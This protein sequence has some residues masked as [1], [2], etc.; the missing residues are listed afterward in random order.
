MMGILDVERPEV[1][2]PSITSIRGSSGGG[3]FWRR[4]RKPR[5][6]RAFAE[7]LGASRLLFRKEEEFPTVD[8]H[9]VNPPSRFIVGC[10]LRNNPGI[11]I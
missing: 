7:W 5:V 3:A 2:E 6:C 1:G 11:L 10:L 9:R 4:V 8:A